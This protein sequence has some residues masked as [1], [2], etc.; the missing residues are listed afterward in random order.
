MAAD[1]DASEAARSL[2]ALRWSPEARLRAA[3]DTVVTRSADLDDS[4]RAA[5][6]AAITAP[7]GDG[8]GES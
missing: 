8:D 2:A 6:E 4:Q 1:A 7:G 5:I 3:V